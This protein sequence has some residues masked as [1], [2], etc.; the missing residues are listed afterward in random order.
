MR[1]CRLHSAQSA[2][3]L[4]TD[5]HQTTCL[6]GEEVKPEAENVLQV[7]KKK[8]WILLPLPVWTYKP[9][10]QII[11]ND[12]RVSRVGAKRKSAPSAFRKSG[13]RGGGDTL[14]LHLSSSLFDMRAGVGAWCAPAASRA[15]IR[16]KNIKVYVHLSALSPGN[17]GEMLLWWHKFK[18]LSLSLSLSLWIEASM[19]H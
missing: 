2:A 3:V 11:H 17:T 10:I 5:V 18:Q 7:G 9:I 16:L 4:R 1:S 6:N 8:K 15:A 12:A 13:K 14:S 19:H